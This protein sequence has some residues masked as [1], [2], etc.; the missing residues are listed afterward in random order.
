MKV[1]NVNMRTSNVTTSTSGDGK[2]IHKSN[3]GAFSDTFGGYARENEREQL[4][5]KLG[6][7]S[8]KGK[9][10]RD[11]M[12]IRDLMEYKKLITEFLERTVKFSHKYSKE[13]KFGRDGSYKVIG[14]VNKVNEELEALTQELMIQEKDKLKIVE[15]IS[16]IQ[17]LLVDMLM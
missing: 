15:K 11:R 16:G 1:N 7:I 4:E 17:G 2:K 5:K 3:A 13:T 12:D 10:V 9:F 14:M 8:E 6:E